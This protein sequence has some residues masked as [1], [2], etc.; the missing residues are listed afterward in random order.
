MSHLLTSL[1]TKAAAAVI[2]AL[3]MRLLVQLWNAYT[4]GGH[5]TPAAV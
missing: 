2:E 5:P 3:V 4:R 1:L